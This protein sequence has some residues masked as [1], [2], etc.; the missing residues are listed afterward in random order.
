VRNSADPVRKVAIVP[1]GRALGATEQ[2]PAEE[3]H[4][5]SRAEL[6]ARIDVMLGGREGEAMA[7]G[8]ITTGAENDLVQATRLVRRMIISSPRS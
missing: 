5:Y 3:R 6:L 7:M 4:N 8:D 2:R 1:H